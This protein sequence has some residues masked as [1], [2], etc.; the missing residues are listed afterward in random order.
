MQK[1]LKSN[2]AVSETSSGGNP[3]FQLYAYKYEGGATL[4][5]LAALSGNLSTISLLT[6]ENVVGDLIEINSRMKAAMEHEGGSEGANNI[7]FANILKDALNAYD[8]AANTPIHMAALSG[9]VVMF[10]YMIYLGSDPKRLGFMGKT[11]LHYAASRGHW[12][13]CQYLIYDA[14]P[15]PSLIALDHSGSSASMN[16]FAAG[17]KQLGA[18]IK[19]STEEVRTKLLGK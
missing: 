15:Y 6:S 14:L 1:V 11:V 16:A 18:M 5:H 12:E 17:Y 9:N 7:K 4:L 10:E 3:K 19:E 13:L 2:N 8:D